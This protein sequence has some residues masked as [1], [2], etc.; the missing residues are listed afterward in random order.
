MPKVREQ[1]RGVFDSTVKATQK[2]KENEAASNAPASDSEDLEPE[3]AAGTKR[4]HDEASGEAQAGVVD[5]SASDG[6]YPPKKQQTT[7]PPTD[8]SKDP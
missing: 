3:V 1:L 5:S 2:A 6:L 8:L 7:S 4:K